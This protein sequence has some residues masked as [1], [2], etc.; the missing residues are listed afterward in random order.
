M[1][2]SMDILSP[3]ALQSLGLAP[4]FLDASPLDMTDINDTVY[5]HSLFLP[6][7]N[8]TVYQYSL[9][10]PDI[11]PEPS[12][13]QGLGE[14]GS[15]FAILPE[16]V[17]SLGPIQVFPTVDGQGK[18]Q[19]RRFS[20]AKR[21][22]VAQVR[23]DGACMRCHLSK[24]PCSTGQ[25][26]KTCFSRWLS[27]NNRSKKLQW[28]SC[29][30]Y[31]WKD[32]NI[33]MPDPQFKST[34]AWQ[35]CVMLAQERTELRCKEVV[36]WD[37][38]ALCTDFATWMTADN[39]QPAATSRVGVLS[40]MQCQRLLCRYL[41]DDLCIYLPLLVRTSSLLYN[42]Q[43][44]PHPCYTNEHLSSA[45]SLLGN[46]LLKNLETAL[47]P[48]ALSKNSKQQLEVL[49][50][51]VFGTIIAVIYTCNTDSE[52]ARVELIQILTHYLVLIGERVGLLQCDMKKLQLTQDCHNLWNKTGGFGWDYNTQ[53]APNDMA[54]SALD[55]N[56]PAFMENHS[57]P[58]SS[59]GTY[60]STL[61]YDHHHVSDPF[62]SL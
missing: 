58:G 31:S 41:D 29:V 51:V 37:V 14:V 62:L 15:D 45:R 47:K 21:Q 49:F 40:S 48:T 60:N 10:L 22:E 17:A 59:T 26:C 38:S 6:D 25:P 52:G 11:N 30:P 53:S 44:S 35:T 4:D 16:F 24:T 46:E 32:V 43:D 55:E 54:F 27:L 18:R 50:I 5:Q 57:N 3:G 28:M 56:S 23:K 19:R 20:D 13:L 36:H 2:E 42:R 39:A 34:E 61:P 7:I 9:L 1:D 33:F 8:D 12:E